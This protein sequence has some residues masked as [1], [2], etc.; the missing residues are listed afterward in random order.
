MIVLVKVYNIDM[1]IFFYTIKHITYLLKL[2]NK[3][4]AG[5]YI[6]EFLCNEPNGNTLN[7]T[8]SPTPSPIFNP[9]ISP[10]IMTN[11]PSFSPTVNPTFAPTVSPSEMPSKSLTSTDYPTHSPSPAPTSHSHPTFSSTRTTEQIA[12]SSTDGISPGIPITHNPTPMTTIIKQTSQTLVIL[13]S[14]K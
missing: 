6:Q 4:G 13:P 14:V 8:P 1:N 2:K 7:P 10:T 3:K 5:N 12:P 11:S 9:T